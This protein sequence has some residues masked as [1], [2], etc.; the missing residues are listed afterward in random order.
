MGA[1]FAPTSKNQK[2]TITNKNYNYG[3]ADI[4]NN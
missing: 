2:D 1:L 4:E 3:K